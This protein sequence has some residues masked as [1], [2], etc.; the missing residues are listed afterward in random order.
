MATSVMLATST[1]ITPTTR[2]RARGREAGRIGLVEHH[3]PVARVHDGVQHLLAPKPRELLG[4]ARCEG[5]AQV[6]ATLDA[7]GNSPEAEG[8]TSGKS[9]LLLR[10][11]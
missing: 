5:I 8:V 6:S 11:G 4:K 2:L 3:D 7:R 10:S 9:P 1:A